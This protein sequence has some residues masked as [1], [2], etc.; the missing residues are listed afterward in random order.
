MV[1]TINKYCKCYYQNMGKLF[2]MATHIDLC[3]G[4]LQGCHYGFDH[5]YEPDIYPY[6]G[7]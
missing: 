7:L 4:W 3:F 1:Y 5:L 2:I 6:N